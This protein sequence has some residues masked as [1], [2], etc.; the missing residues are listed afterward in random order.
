VLILV[1]ALNGMIL[2]ISL[3]VILVAAYRTKIVGDYKHPLWLTIFGAVIVVVMAIMSGMTM[4]TELPKL[5]A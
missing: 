3:G 1:G 4:F 5:F 2:P